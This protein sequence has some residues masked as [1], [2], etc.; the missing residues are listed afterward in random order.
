M[1][2]GIRGFKIQVFPDLNQPSQFST[3][4]VGF[5]SISEEHV[6]KYFEW[7]DLIVN[8]DVK[9]GGFEK[10]AF[11]PF[12]IPVIEFSFDA[13][14]K[15]LRFLWLQILIEEIYRIVAVELIVGRT[16]KTVSE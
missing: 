3:Q 6:A 8:D 13:C 4:P 16:V 12:R 9:A 5:G 15:I 10:Y 1:R 7:D 11:K 2:P 14:F